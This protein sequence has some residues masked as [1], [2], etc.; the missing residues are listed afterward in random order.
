MSKPG[1]RYGPRQLLLIGFYRSPLQGLKIS[2]ISL[3]Y[4][5][6]IN[7]KMKSKMRIHD[8]SWIFTQLNH[9]IGI[10][11]MVPI[12]K[13]FLFFHS[14]LK[15]NFKANKVGILSSPSP[16]SETFFL[17]I[18]CSMG[19][20]S[21]EIFLCSIYCS[22]PWAIHYF[23]LA[24]FFHQTY[25]FSVWFSYHLAYPMWHWLVMGFS[26]LNKSLT[27]YKIPLTSARLGIVI[28]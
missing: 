27:I 14:H 13:I 25:L 15:P 5:A 19:D 10:L 20:L 26:P 23:F 4:A 8:Y 18:L 28:P 22:M 6:W 7:P 9:S 12:S 11:E 17:P 2:C 21:S 3:L 1:A 16:F 24:L